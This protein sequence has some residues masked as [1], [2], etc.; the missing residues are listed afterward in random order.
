MPGG[1]LIA[2]GQALYPVRTRVNDDYLFDAFGC[3]QHADVFRP[4]V[5]TADDRDP[6][7]FAL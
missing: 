4:P 6:E 7:L 3:V 5:T 2:A 1:R